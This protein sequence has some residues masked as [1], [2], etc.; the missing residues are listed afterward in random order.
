[1][2][3]I[4]GLSNKKD[5]TQEIRIPN[6]FSESEKISRTIFSPMNIK[7]DESLRN[8]SFTTPA[9]LDEVSVNRLD[10]STPNF[11]KKIS[12]FIANPDSGRSY[13]GI[14]IIDVKEISDSDSDIVYTPNEIEINDVRLENKFH[15]DIKIGFVKEAGKPLPMKFAY[16]VEQMVTKARF[17]KD[18]DSNS[19]TWNGDD[20]V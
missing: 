5:V 2:Q 20:L 15:S 19:E 6:D 1:M 18:N 13:F 14:A 12:K 9:G 7:S 8:N 4:L 17:Y 11:I 16:K 3:N 10:Y